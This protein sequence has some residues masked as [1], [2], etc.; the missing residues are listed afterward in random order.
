MSWFPQIGAGSI[1]QFPLQ[2]TRKW[3]SIAN[4]MESGERIF[5]PDTTAGQ[6]EWR[7]RLQELTDA[8]TAKLNDFFTAAQ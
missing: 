5:L 1:A 3:R 4:R 8:E 2:R 7:F 6:V